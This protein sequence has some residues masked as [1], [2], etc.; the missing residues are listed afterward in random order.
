MKFSISD[1]LFAFLLVG[2][3]VGWFVEHR[4]AVELQTEIDRLETH[5]GPDY[6]AYRYHPNPDRSMFAKDPLAEV[7]RKTRT[8]F[9][10]L[11]TQPTAW[12]N[13][14]NQYLGLDRIREDLD[15][16]LTMTV[17][18]HDEVKDAEGDR[19]FVYLADRER[20]PNTK[21]ADRLHSSFSAY[22]VTDAK[23][24]LVHWNGCEID[25]LL[26]T[27]I[28]LSGDTFPAGLKYR[29]QSRHN[30]DSSMEV[31]QLTK[32]GITN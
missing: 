13:G 23:N 1:L 24:T 6:F 21:S 5:F 11:V 8:L 25:R 15:P 10:A 17:W 2:V 7:D 26:V 19:F 4:R 9:K 27:E 16:E 31:R 20:G 30:G 12:S 3:G 22:I 29:E 14:L 18:W 28:E 32:S